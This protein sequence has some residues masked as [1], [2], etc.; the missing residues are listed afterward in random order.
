MEPRDLGTFVKFYTSVCV[1]YTQ[2]NRKKKNRLDRDV[3]LSPGILVGP[4]VS[5]FFSFP[6]TFYRDFLSGQTSRGL[7]LAQESGSGS[8]GN[9]SLFYVIR[10]VVY[11]SSS[12]P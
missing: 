12:K 3:A 1:L 11:P 10:G 5:F 9:D 8:Q 7:G 4:Y 2:K 6:K